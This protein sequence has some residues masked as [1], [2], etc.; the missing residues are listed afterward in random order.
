MFET[1]IDETRVGA[2]RDSADKTTLKK[3]EERMLEV[4]R[5]GRGF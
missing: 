5:M 4:M 3:R 1:L 2:M